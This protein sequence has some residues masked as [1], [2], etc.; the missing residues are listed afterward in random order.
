MKTLLKKIGYFL[1]QW[2]GLW[3]LP[4]AILVFVTAAL[5]GQQLFGVWFVPMPLDDL[6]AALEAAIIVIAANTVTQLGL[7]FNFRSLYRYYLTESK[8]EFKQ[9]PSWQKISLL[10]FIYVFFFVAFL[11]V[12]HSLTSGPSILPN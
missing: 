9:L 12:W 11:I 2:D 7:W 6:H 1:S 10:L 5:F 3:S 4:I 8:T